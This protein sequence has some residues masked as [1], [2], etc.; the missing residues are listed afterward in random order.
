MYSNIGKL[1][2]ARFYWQKLV[3]LY[4]GSV[5]AEKAKQLLENLKQ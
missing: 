5:E 2:D 1:N 4:A 3:D